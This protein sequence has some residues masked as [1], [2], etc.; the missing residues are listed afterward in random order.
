MAATVS[1]RSAACRFPARRHRVE[2]LFREENAR[3]TDETAA[4]LGVEAVRLCDGET[5]STLA[6]EAA[7][8]ALERAGV[9]AS[10]LDVIVDFSILPQEYLVPAWNMSNKLQHEL[11]A[12]GAFTLGFSGGGATNF[13]VALKAAADL[14]RFDERVNTALLVAADVTIP[15]N[16]I[17]T[18]DAPTVV[19]GDGASAMLL[20]GDAPRPRV[21]DVELWS[22]GGYHDVCFIPG[23]ALAHPDRPDLYRL[24]LDRER[25][26]AAPKWE[27]LDRLAAAVLARAGRTRDERTAFVYPNLSAPDRAAF[28][29][30]FALDP[31]RAVHAPFSE[32]GHVQGSDFVR[33]YLALVENGTRADDDTALLCSHG[34]GFLYGVGLL[35]F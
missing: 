29:D 6:L 17:L 15:G 24:I 9:D 5:G 31:R 25:F 30:A 4:R 19:L 13:L 11:G 1:I 8:E 35:G 18:P 2:T 34:M 12:T 22:D 26:E 14:I 16:R 23:G 21:L 3:F 10:A 28:V 7:R 27:T 33:N 32:H 20:Q